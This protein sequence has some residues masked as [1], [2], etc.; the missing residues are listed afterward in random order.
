M[1]AR[2][3]TH[4]RTAKAV[5]ARDRDEGVDLSQETRTPIKLDRCPRGARRSLH[6]GFCLGRCMCCSTGRGIAC[7]I[8]SA[9]P[10][11][12]FFA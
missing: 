3:H 1:S 5:K 6:K 8:G 10:I 2:G 9:A 7:V 11:G 4:A 12:Y